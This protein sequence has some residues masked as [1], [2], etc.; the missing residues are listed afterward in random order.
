MEQLFL[1]HP[2]LEPLVKLG[3]AM[4]LGMVI[5]IERILAHKTAGMRTYALVSMGAALFVIISQAT[6][7]ITLG[8]GF[9]DSNIFQIPA[10]IVSG[11]G[12]LGAGLMIWHDHTLTGVTTATS[13][14]VCAGI[15]MAV[16]F[17]LFA[18]GITATLLT[19]FVFT[20]LWFV[21][22][23]IKKFQTDTPYRSKKIAEGGETPNA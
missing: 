9:T 22:E 12:F 21:E 7:K 5:G 16:G 15:G 6:A 2:Y 23:Y 13:I 19:L 1:S 10:A 3:L 8:E 17:G 11:I 4:L 18:L 14:W 20:V